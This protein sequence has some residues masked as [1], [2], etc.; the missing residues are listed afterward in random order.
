MVWSLSSVKL[1]C[2]KTLENAQSSPGILIRGLCLN[3]ESANLG[4]KLK[5]WYLTL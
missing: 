3:G 2:L 1:I 5:P 4:L